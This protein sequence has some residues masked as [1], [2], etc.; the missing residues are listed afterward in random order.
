MICV[1]ILHSK[2]LD[3]FYTGLSRFSAK[4]RR[5][6]I[7]GQNHWTSRASDWVEIWQTRMM[8]TREARDLEKA[9]KARGARRFLVEKGIEIPPTGTN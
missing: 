7:K 1:Y 9:I 6:H 3:C 8:S 5:Q 2:T 4:R